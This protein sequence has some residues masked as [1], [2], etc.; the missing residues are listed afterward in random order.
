MASEIHVAYNAVWL[1]SAEEVIAS[2]RWGD[3]VREVSD[4]NAVLTRA[5][6]LAGMD[7]DR[8]EAHS[9]A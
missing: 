1:E 4:N 9:A 3:E 2:L 7:F 6:Q 5:A 8:R